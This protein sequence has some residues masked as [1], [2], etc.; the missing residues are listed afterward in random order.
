[1]ILHDKKKTNKSESSYIITSYFDRLAGVLC[2]DKPLES[3]R[4]IID[5]DTSLSCQKLNV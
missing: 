4:E 2:G 1:M 5:L 3:T